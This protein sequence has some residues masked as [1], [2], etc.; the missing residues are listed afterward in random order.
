MIVSLHIFAIIDTLLAKL[1]LVAVVG[2]MNLSTS[3]FLAIA[4]QAHHDPKSY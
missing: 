4:R 3:G 1:S 2:S